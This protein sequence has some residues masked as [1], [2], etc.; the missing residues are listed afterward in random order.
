MLT[1]AQLKGLRESLFRRRDADGSSHLKEVAIILLGERAGV[2]LSALVL[3]LLVDHSE[4]GGAPVGR[5]TRDARTR[6]C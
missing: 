4:D 5:T 6:R 2:E 3:A 1:R